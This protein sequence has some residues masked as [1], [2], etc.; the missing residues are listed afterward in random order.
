MARRIDDEGTRKDSLTV[1]QRLKTQKGS[2]REHGAV[3]DTTGRLG[4]P[5][6]EHS[7]SK[8]FRRE[9]MESENET[10]YGFPE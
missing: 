5:V 4:S 1:A 10:H 3:T 2:K 7:V 9:F 8:H 6:I